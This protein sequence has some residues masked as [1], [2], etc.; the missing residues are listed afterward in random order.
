MG[1]AD[2]DSRV[3]PHE[4]IQLVEDAGAA[5][6]GRSHRGAGDAELGERTQA[7]DE[8]G[9]EQDVDDVGEPEDPHRDRGVAGASEDGVDE[10]Q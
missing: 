9:A 4:T 3:A 2:R 5:A 8:T 1:A 6:D 10:E 7:E